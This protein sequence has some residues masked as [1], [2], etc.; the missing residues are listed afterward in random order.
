M[1]LEL[2]PSDGCREGSPLSVAY[3]GLSSLTVFFS[4]GLPSRYVSVSKSLF[5]DTLH[6]G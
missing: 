2:V 4:R 1:S 3:I 5:K 6:I